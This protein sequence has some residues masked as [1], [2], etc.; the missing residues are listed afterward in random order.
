[1]NRHEHTDSLLASLSVVT[2]INMLGE[3]TPPSPGSMLIV[4]I[5]ES[6]LLLGYWSELS[7]EVTYFRMKKQA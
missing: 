7:Q 1:M 4:C 5:S 3:G 2:D 6:I